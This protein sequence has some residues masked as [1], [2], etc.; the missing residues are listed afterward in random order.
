MSQDVPP[1]EITET[2]PTPIVR[3]FG[4]FLEAAGAPSAYVTA[5]KQALDRK[6]L[7]ALDQQ[8]QT[9]RTAAH[10]R[11]DQEYYPLLNFFQRLCMGG[12]LHVLDKVRGKL[13]M[14]PT[15]RAGQFRELSPAG[16]YLAL[17]EA[18]WVDCNWEQL[19]GGL[20]R[21]GEDAFGIHMALEDIAPLSAGQT[22]VGGRR[23]GRH[24]LFLLNHGALLTY[25]GFFGFLV[26]TPD[27]QA[28]SDYGRK[29]VIVLKTVTIT[30]IGEHFLKVLREDRPIALWN[31]PHQKH[32]PPEFPG[33]S[34]KP[35]DGGVEVET[36]FV[37]AFRPLLPADAA[38]L[39]LPRPVRQPKEGTYV[40][41]VSLGRVW[42]TIAVSHKHTL[43]D[44][45]L[46]IQH[47]FKFDND[48]L[49]A[50]Y[51]D[52]RP[53]SHDRY[54]DPRGDEGPFADEA[55]VGEL[56]LYVRQKILYLFDFGDE[57]RFDVELCE[58]LEASHAGSP[59]V[60][61]AKGDPPPQYPQWEDDE[62]F[63]EEWD[64]DDEDFDEDFEEDEADDAEDDRSGPDVT[65]EGAP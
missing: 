6:T 11:T 63:D 36:P 44:L 40:F 14:V 31:L 64:E 23:G 56:D 49:Y 52:G 24:T 43:E 34:C 29:G 35:G 54:E 42:R 37:D 62:E 12:R 9:H 20:L 1:F 22:I 5:A 50:F 51:M 26:C 21:S 47:A 10:S 57:W 4:L 32:D 61:A 59:K 19:P 13:R 53:Y 27:P 25:L 55:A 28:E 33:Q 30:P 41:R 48:H 38:G 46:A 45:H 18:A 15:Q 2:W 39:V 65:A 3:D 58:V 8:M 7:H 60:I 16:K 17:L